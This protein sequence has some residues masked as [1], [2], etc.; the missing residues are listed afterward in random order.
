MPEG[1]M[2]DIVRQ[3]QGFGHIL[4]QSQNRSDRPGYLRDLQGVGK[5][6]AKVVGETGREDLGLILQPSKCPRVN[7]PVAVAAEFVAIGMG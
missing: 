6:I 2:A 7:Y 3:G 5:A 1:R 4:S